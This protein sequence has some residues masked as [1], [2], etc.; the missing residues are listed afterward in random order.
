MAVAAEVFAGAGSDPSARVKVANIPSL[1][2]PPP[3]SHGPP[4][5]SVARDRQAAL[6]IEGETGRQ[7]IAGTSA[8]ERL[9][10][11]LFVRY[12]RLKCPVT[13]P[14]AWRCS[15]LQTSSVSESDAFAVCGMHHRDGHRQ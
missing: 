2:P 7:Q 4:H 11:Q 1:L 12:T 5:E 13:T 15:V 9:K 6:C 3:H 10:R 14:L 8:T